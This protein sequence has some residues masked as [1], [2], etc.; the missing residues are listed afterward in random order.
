MRVELVCRAAVDGVTNLPMVLCV[1]SVPSEESG[2]PAQVEFTRQISDSG[3]VHAT[4][5]S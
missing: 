5:L 4:L 1:G 3:G 2:I